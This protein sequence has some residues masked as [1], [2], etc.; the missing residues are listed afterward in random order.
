MLPLKSLGPSLVAKPVANE[1]GVTGVDEHGDLL[2]NLRNEAVDGLHPVTMEQEVTVN[3][4][5]AAIVG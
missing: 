3:V 2:Q 1:V 5:V 4:E